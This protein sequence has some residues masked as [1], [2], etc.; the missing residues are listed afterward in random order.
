MMQKQWFTTLALATAALLIAGCSSTEINSPDKL[1]TT[2]ISLSQPNFKVLKADATGTSH[3]FAFLGI[4]PIV[5][6]KI[7]VAKERLY[8]TVGEPIAGRAVALANQADYHSTVYLILFSV[9]K[10]TVTADVIEFVDP[11]A[12]AAPAGSTAASL[13]PAA[14]SR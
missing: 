1:T 10:L 13:L 8:A 4:I 9:P 12:H 14:N 2:G 3:G 11:N 5:N 6:P 7:A